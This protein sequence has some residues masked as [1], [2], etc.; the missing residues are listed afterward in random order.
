VNEEGLYILG[1]SGLLL[2]GG[3]DNSIIQAERMLAENSFHEAADQGI[4][5]VER[6]ASEEPM[7]SS[8]SSGDYEAAGVKIENLV[9]DYADSRITVHL[10]PGLHKEDSTQDLFELGGQKVFESK[11][12]KSKHVIANI[13]SNLQYLNLDD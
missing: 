8:N 4:F 12:V 10:Q 3:L 11:S 2:H 9:D 1:Q 7:D 13:R 6:M 5:I